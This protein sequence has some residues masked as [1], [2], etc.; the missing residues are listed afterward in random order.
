MKRWKKLLI[1]LLLLVVVTQLPFVYRRYKL[2]RLNATVQ[3]LNSQRTSLDNESPFENPYEDYPGVIHVHSFL[4]G[5]SSGGFQEIIDAARATR[6]SFVVMTEH[7]GKEF[8]TAEKTL[9][10]R[11]GGVLFVN[12][13]EVST[14]EG[15][16]LLIVPGDEVT[17]EFSGPSERLS[18][19][20]LLQHAR[21]RGTLAI[22]AYP[23]DFK[24]WSN[25]SF[26]AIE[27]YN[28]YTNALEI[29]PV[30]AFFDTIWSH[31]SYPSLLFASYYRRP[32]S[33][34]AKFDEVSRS[35]KVVALA[36]NDAHANVGVSLNDSS[37]KT[38]LG[39]KLDP[40]ETSFK[41]VRVHVLVPAGVPR[42]SMDMKLPLETDALLKALA[43]GHCF[44]GF[45]LLSDST[46]FTFTAD[47]GVEKRIQGDEISLTNNVRLLISSPLPARIVLLKDGSVIQTRDAT[48][49]QEFVVTERGVYRVELS[50]PQLP[51]RVSGEPWIISNPI[52]VR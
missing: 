38:L 24:S 22:A 6:L 14:S 45:D 35:R 7:P 36:G 34:L 32:A 42:G 48:K 2:R 12:G 46:G 37:G 23:K 31:R 33:A 40:Y 26:G 49:Q 20:S 43:G 51:H 16:R 9:S 29:N 28:V 10:G 13:N 1:G 44:I 4:G 30:V 17:G 8:N 21:E 41:L 50:L 3:E 27:V 39:L 5:H 15:D 19:V 18:T 47:N 25:D 52:Y 11:F